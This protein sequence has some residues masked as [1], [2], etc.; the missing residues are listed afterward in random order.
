MRPPP[1]PPL[2]SPPRA[3]APN[4]RAPPRGGRAQYAGGGGPPPP[5]PPREPPPPPRRQ[6]LPKASLGR[7][8]RAGGLVGGGAS[9]D[10]LDARLEVRVHLSSADLRDLRRRDPGPPGA[11]PEPGTARRHAPS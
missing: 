6:I 11:T 2:A 3:W 7:R 4:P 8:A 10:Q 5:R 1:P 9:R